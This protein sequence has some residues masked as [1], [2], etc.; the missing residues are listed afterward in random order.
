MGGA[1]WPQWVASGGMMGQWLAVLRSSP[2]TAS[3]PSPT[4]LS[5]LPNCCLQSDKGF[6][7]Q[8]VMRG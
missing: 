7:D 5:A 6:S 2:L 3:P 1:V 8:R 4:E